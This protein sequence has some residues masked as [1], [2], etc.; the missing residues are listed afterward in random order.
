MR[1]RD[2]AGRLGAVLYESVKPLDVG[3]TIGVV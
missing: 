1:K 2:E 3:G